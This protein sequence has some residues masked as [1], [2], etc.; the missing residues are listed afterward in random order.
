MVVRG[1]TEKANRDILERHVL[2]W[3]ELQKPLRAMDEADKR[4]R[5]WDFRGMFEDVLLAEIGGQ[6]RRQ[7]RI[8]IGKNRKYIKVAKIIENNGSVVD[9]KLSDLK[10]ARSFLAEKMA[11][12]QA[13]LLRIDM[14][15]EVAEEWRVKVITDD[16]IEEAD[17][18]IAEEAG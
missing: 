1:Q 18:R 8:A 15:I 13:R 11:G 17:S 4:V 3:K 5:G 9:T 2:K 7:G 10:R 16:V 14:I 12:Y 6:Q